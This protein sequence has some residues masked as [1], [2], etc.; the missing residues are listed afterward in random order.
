MTTMGTTSWRRWPVLAV[1]LLSV[2]LPTAATAAVSGVSWKKP[3]VSTPKWSIVFSPT[4]PTAATRGPVEVPLDGDSFVYGGNNGTVALRSG[5]TVTMPMSA[6]GGATAQLEQCSVA[7]DTAGNICPGTVSV[8]AV[9]DGANVYALP[10]SYPA[11]Y[12]IQFRV[13]PTAGGAGNTL[14]LGAT[15]RWH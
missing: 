13:H 11:G 9:T 14:T 6:T 15:V 2:L 12:S 4:A 8:V 7:W 5:F 1:V 3:V 10:S